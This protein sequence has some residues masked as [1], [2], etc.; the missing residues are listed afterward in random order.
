MKENVETSLVQI[1][2]VIIIVLLTLTTLNQFTKTDAD[3]EYTT[4]LFLQVKKAISK[5]NVF[6]FD[7][8]RY[9]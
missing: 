9:F 3:F 7:M 5:R 4:N 8:G 6:I 2:N 1:D